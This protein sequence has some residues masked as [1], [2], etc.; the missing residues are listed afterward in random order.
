MSP[1]TTRGE[2]GQASSPPTARHRSRRALRPTRRTRTLALLFVLIGTAVSI[3]RVLVSDMTD[4][5]AISGDSV[6]YDLGGR[7]VASLLSRPFSSLARIAKGDFSPGERAELGL[8][9]RYNGGLLRSPTYCTFLGTIYLLGGNRVRLVGV[10]QSLLF[11]LVVGLT[12]LIARSY[13]SERWSAVTAL[14]VVTYSSF[15]TYVPLLLTET[16][17]LFLV[18]SAVA[19]VRPVLRR[20]KPAWALALGVVAALLALCRV[21]F[22]WMILVLLVFLVVEAMRRRTRVFRRKPLYFAL[23]AAAVLGPW[24]AFSARVY[25]EPLLAAPMSDETAYTLFRGNYV[26]EDGWE[27]DGIGDSWG[28]EFLAAKA[29][30]PTPEEWRRGEVHLDAF[31]RTVRAYPKRFAVLMVRKAHRLWF[32]PAERWETDLGFARLPGETRWHQG[33]VVLALLGLGFTFRAARRLWYVPALLAYITAV[34]AASHVENRFT[35]PF[36]PV[37]IIL[38]VAFLA[39]LFRKRQTL[40][41]L[42]RTRRFVVGLGVAL[43]SS[44]LAGFGSVGRLQALFPSTP[45]EPLHTVSILLALIATLAWAAPLFF[46]HRTGTSRARALTAA[47]LPLVLLGFARAGAEFGDPAWR[48][49]SCTLDSPEQKAVQVLFLP[50]NIAWRHITE[51]AIQV[52]MLAPLGSR[53]PVYVTVNGRRIEAYPNGLE[54]DDS[55]F[56][57]TDGVPPDRR[58]RVLDRLAGAVDEMSLPEGA[59]L[60]SIRQWFR[61]PIDVSEVA[62][63]TRVRIEVGVNPAPGDRSGIQVFGDYPTPQTG[64]TSAQVTEYFGPPLTRTQFQ[65]SSFKFRMM[66]PDRIA[67]DYRLYQTQKLRSERVVA[68]RVDDGRESFDLS[69]AAGLQSGQYRIRL[70]L[71]LQG[72]H[73]FVRAE[74]KP[75]GVAWKTDPEPGLERVAG[76]HL[77]RIQCQKYV[78]VDGH[79]VF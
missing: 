46:L 79:A 1:G 42:F 62:G 74:G 35:V 22:Q 51:A 6:Y 53:T 66:A 40:G 13:L 60:E 17:A 39:Y 21:T 54:V 28:P 61:I 25:G 11:G 19:L 65:V 44:A 71:T 56:V 49:W 64:S 32:R 78:Y 34:H 69:P 75:V 70:D 10:A 30:F 37:V 57:F 16:L 18:T 38:A 5:S 41:R 59:G 29:A 8:E 47:I 7:G 76:D 36:M 26:P 50:T 68:T 77:R 14:A 27:N 52:D 58:T 31:R 55:K 2:A 33:I 43:L 15:F 24:L 63:R 48:E 20:E 23:G 73:Y 67:A 45:A 4:A 72:G 3:A 9:K 12:F